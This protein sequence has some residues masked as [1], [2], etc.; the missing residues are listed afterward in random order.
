MSETLAGTALRMP[1][2]ARRLQLG[3]AFQTHP[4]RGETG[5]RG[6]RTPRFE[7]VVAPGGER[8]YEDERLCPA[9][10]GTKEI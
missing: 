2:I 10:L 9:E 4:H 6:S 7:Q 1:P 8:R 3:A 5:A